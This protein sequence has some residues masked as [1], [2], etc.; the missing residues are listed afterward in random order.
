MTEAK[1]VIVEG[2]C[3]VEILSLSDRCY[4]SSNIVMHDNLKG[5]VARICSLLLPGFAAADGLSSL[6][7]MGSLRKR[8]G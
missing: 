4:I 3:G 8:D 1:R 5:V 2:K 7:S 6:P